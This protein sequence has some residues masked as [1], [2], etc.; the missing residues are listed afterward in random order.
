M[1]NYSKWAKYHINPMNFTKSKINIP[2]SIKKPDWLNSQNPIYSSKILSI[3]E[4]NSEDLKNLREA[5]EIAARA[6]D[7][8][9][10]LSQ[11]VKNGEELDKKL[12]EF[13][14]KKE[15]YPSGIGF[16]DFPKSICISTNDILVHGIPNEREF[17]EGD[18]MNLDVTVYKNGFY[19][20]NSIMATIGDVEPEIKKLVF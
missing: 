6:K 7:F 9:K 12:T 11:K 13:I 14:I 1:K 19:G 2:S 3:L 20:D 15:A 16:M 18:W 8:A 10:E 4:K 5:C 17:Q